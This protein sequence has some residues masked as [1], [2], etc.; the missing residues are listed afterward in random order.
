VAR[1]VVKK[2]GPWVPEDLAIFVI[3]QLDATPMIQA[4][5]ELFG[6]LEYTP[7]RAAARMLDPAA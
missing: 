7:P 3:D 1:I 2:P 4:L 5:V 6:S